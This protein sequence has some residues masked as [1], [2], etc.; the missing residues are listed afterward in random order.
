MAL[1]NGTKERQRLQLRLL[2]IFGQLGNY[3][4]IGYHNFSIK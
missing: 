3:W 2:T 4:S 1:E